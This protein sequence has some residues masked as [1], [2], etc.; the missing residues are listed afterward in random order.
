MRADVLQKMK[1]LVAEHKFDLAAY[2]DSHVD[3]AGS[4]VHSGA[5]TI[6][7]V[8][9]WAVHA[10]LGPILCIFGSRPPGPIGRSIPSRSS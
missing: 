9:Q 8:R 4:G 5:E 6:S 10:R 7:Q 3:S 1:E 2:Y